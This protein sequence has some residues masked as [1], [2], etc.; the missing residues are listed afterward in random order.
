MTI[1]KKMDP[2]GWNRFIETPEMDEQ[3]AWEE[4][5]KN[6]DCSKRAAEAL[7]IGTPAL[8]RLIVLCE[9]SQSGQTHK[10]ATFLGACWNGRRHF[11]LYDL[12][13][14]SRA[15]SDDML[16]V[17]DVLRWGSVAF[18]CVV[19]DGNARIIGIL[20]KW[21]MYDKDE[22]GQTIVLHE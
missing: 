13:A 8:E 16:L 5:L 14:V 22:N 3:A 19:P 6:T 15:F 7:R 20:E 11:N 1:S 12:R 17:L 21:H 4:L 10:I 18:E 9:Q 2:E